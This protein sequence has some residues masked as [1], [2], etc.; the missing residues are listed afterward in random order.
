MKF[1]HEKPA[2]YDTLHEVFGVEWDDG[3]II[4][5]GDTI[6]S[7]FPISK[8]LEKHEAVHVRQQEAY[9]VESWWDRYLIDPAFRFEQES[10]AYRTQVNYINNTESNREIRFKKKQN[11]VNDMVSMYGSM[12]TRQEA[13]R[14]VGF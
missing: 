5:Y 13:L 3:L 11:I 12:C 7:K 8:D 9:G 6:Y 14:V 10:E 4:T 2:I 1:S